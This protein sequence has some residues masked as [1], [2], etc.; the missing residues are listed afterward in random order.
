M[1]KALN[2]LFDGPNRA[3]SDSNPPETLAITEFPEESVGTPAA[4]QAVL[5]SPTGKILMMKDNDGV[6]TTIGPG[7]ATGTKGS[8]L[9]IATT[10]YNGVDYVIGVQGGISKRFILGDLVPV[11]WV[12]VP[13]IL[14]TTAALTPVAASAAAGV[15]LYATSKVTRNKL[16]LSWATQVRLAGMVIANGNVAGVNWQLQYATAEA[17]TWSSS[18]G[19]ADAGAGITLGAG[20]TG[21]I[22]DSGWQTLAVGARIDNC[23]IAMVNGTTAQG[24]TAPTIGSLSVF[25]R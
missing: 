18:T 5:F 23:F 8:A 19:R 17:S 11:P 24:T 13:L 20:T 16:D 15:E 22:R 4:G 25:F 1:V 7:A 21:V 6:V 12:E 3:Y 10:P 14:G 9:P 2:G